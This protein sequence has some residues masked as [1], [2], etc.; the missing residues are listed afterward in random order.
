MNNA[1]T[2]GGI[3]ANGRTYAEHCAW[4]DAMSPDEKLILYSPVGNR[5]TLVL[6]SEAKRALTAELP[7][8]LR[9]R[10]LEFLDSLPDVWPAEIIAS[11][12]PMCDAAAEIMHE[13]RKLGPQKAFDKCAE[14]DVFNAFVALNPSLLEALR[15]RENMRDLLAARHEY[16][17]E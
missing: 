7:V 11:I 6:I 5:Y 13:A 8:E 16:E 9:L 3:Y 17:R 10:F 12:A 14:W 2:D 4:I 1:I 15:M